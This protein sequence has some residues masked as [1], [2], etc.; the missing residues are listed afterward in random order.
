PAQAL[1]DILALEL[2]LNDLSGPWCDAHAGEAKAILGH[3]ISV[4]AYSEENLPVHQTRFVEGDTARIVG[5]ELEAVYRFQLRQRH[6]TTCGSIDNTNFRIVIARRGRRLGVRKNRTGQFCYGYSQNE[7][8]P[9]SAERAPH[10]IH[11]VRFLP[12]ELIMS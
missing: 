7:R 1:G 5:D 4:A 8:R 11:D 10:S 12:N 2:D 6:A 9:K 3:F